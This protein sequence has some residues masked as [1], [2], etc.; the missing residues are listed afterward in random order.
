MLT[1]CS[2][3]PFD[4]RNRFCQHNNS[5]FI[6]IYILHLSLGNKG[7]VHSVKPFLGACVW[8]HSSNT[9]FVLLQQ[10]FVNPGVFRRTMIIL[11]CYVCR[12]ILY[13]SVTLLFDISCYWAAH[14]YTRIQ[15]FIFQNNRFKSVPLL[16]TIEHR[17]ECT[18]KLFYNIMQTPLL[19]PLS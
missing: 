19:G 15:A 7:L 12:C 1:Q 17:T 2:L 18:D 6:Y 4:K 3:P 16:R 9:L 10:P 8:A 13:A 11:Y 14:F 5:I